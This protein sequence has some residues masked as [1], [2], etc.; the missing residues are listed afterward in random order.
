MRTPSLRNDDLNLIFMDPFT[1]KDYWEFEEKLSLGD[2]WPKKAPQNEHEMF[3]RVQYFQHAAA[4]KLF[5]MCGFEASETTTT[6]RSIAQTVKTGSEYVS[7]FRKKNDINF[8]YR[9]LQAVVTLTFITAN[10]RAYRK[11]SL[12][13]FAGGQAICPEIHWAMLGFEPGVVEEKEM[14][15]AE[16]LAGKTVNTAFDDAKKKLVAEVKVIK[17]EDSQ[18][19]KHD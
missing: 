7:D 9:A 6:K 16:K 10:K 5:S 4:N 18:E 8:R 15:I 1:K 12:S 13:F 17:G 14:Q 3:H 19:T 11:A 2:I